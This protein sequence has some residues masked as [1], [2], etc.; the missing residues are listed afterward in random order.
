VFFKIN[1]RKEYIVEKN[2]NNHFL[3]NKL[4]LST[5]I[6]LLKSRFKTIYFIIVCLLCHLRSERNACYRSVLSIAAHSPRVLG[7]VGEGACCTQREN[8]RYNERTIHLDFFASFHF[9]QSL[10]FRPRPKISRDTGEID[11]RYVTIER[12]AFIPRPHICHCA[13]FKSFNVCK[14][15]NF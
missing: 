2:N 4:L 13:N 5:K 12:R 1:N 7:H 10:R 15:L 9:R 14:K 11:F 3:S 6:F 8:L